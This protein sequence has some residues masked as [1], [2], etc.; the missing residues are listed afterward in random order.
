[1]ERNSYIMIPYCPCKHDKSKRTLN[2][3]H[4]IKHSSLK[5]HLCWISFPQLTSGHS[6]QS[7]PVKDNRNALL[8]ANEKTNNAYHKF[9][10]CVRSSELG[11]SSHNPTVLQDGQAKYS[12]TIT[13]KSNQG[14]QT[15]LSYMHRQCTTT[16]TVPP[17]LF[18]E[19]LPKK[20]KIQVGAGKA[21]SLFREGK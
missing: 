14:P 11:S 2:I 21:S 6:C 3:M 12:H 9:M 8:K 7:P 10:N 15:K 5:G 17:Q 18:K 1:M 16:H 4:W 13:T 20:K 19:A